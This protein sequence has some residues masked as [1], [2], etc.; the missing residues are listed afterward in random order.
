MSINEIGDLWFTE[1]EWFSYVFLY[2]VCV[3]MKCVVGLCAFSLGREL[4]SK[5]VLF[6]HC[7]L[8][9]TELSACFV[10]VYCI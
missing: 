5:L 8:M 4:E 3:L 1:F 2:E 9:G 10:I 6:V 7:V